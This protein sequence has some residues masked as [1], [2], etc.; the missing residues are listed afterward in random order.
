MPD[1][2]PRKID[3]KNNSDYNTI[4]CI[5]QDHPEYFSTMDTCV[6]VER[7]IGLEFLCAVLSEKTP[8]YCISVPVPILEGQG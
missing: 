5:S 8:I 3:R 2:I 7:Q 4:F 6:C 1:F